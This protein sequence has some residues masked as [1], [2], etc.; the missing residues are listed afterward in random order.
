MLTLLPNLGLGGGTAPGEPPVGRSVFCAPQAPVRILAFAVL[1]SPLLL[2]TLFVA[3]STNHVRAPTYARQSV[4]PALN[5][6][7]HVNR[8]PLE[9]VVVTPQPQPVALQPSLP[10][11]RGIG[12]ETSRGS[13]VI[14]PQVATPAPFLPFL[15]FRV[16]YPGQ[17]ADTTYSRPIRE[18]V[19]PPV[20]QEVHFS[21]DGA[22]VR[23]LSTPV[24]PSSLLTALTPDIYSAGVTLDSFID[25]PGAPN[26]DTSRGLWVGLRAAVVQDPVFPELQVAPHHLRN[27]PDTSR[28]T[29]KGLLADS[30]LPF[31]TPH[32]TSPDRARPARDTSQGTRIH[33]STIQPPFVNPPGFQV[34]WN[35]WLDDTTQGTSK[36]L[37][38]DSTKPFF[39]APGFLA[40]PKPPVVD[41]SAGI[42]LSLATF[43]PPPIPNMP[44]YIVVYFWK[45]TA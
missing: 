18:V 7:F 15:S 14:L 32:H 27:T 2:T 17:V 45:R 1:G 28:G 38:A 4:L 35:R 37:T 21:P 29:P 13:T 12:V 26:A 5:S 40:H 42:N 36:S 33:L 20:V 11:L 8:L 30:T 22:R 10:F 43:V 41:T 19:V 24:S 25:I 16:E 9:G 34:G 44:P 6:A 39:V 23:A 3:P 31:F